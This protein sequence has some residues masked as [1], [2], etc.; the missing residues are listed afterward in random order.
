M[1]TLKPEE[2]QV[3]QKPAAPNVEKPPETAEEKAARKQGPKF[4]F[5]TIQPWQVKKLVSVWGA[6]LLVAVIFLS[7]AC[8]FLYTDKIQ[9]DDYWTEH[10]TQPEETL[11]R[12]AQKSA[13]ATVVTVGSYVESMKEMSLKTSSFRAVV[14]LWFRW[15]GH[16]DLD[17]SQNFHVYNG[18]INKLEVL[19][20]YHENGEHYQLFRCDVTVGKNYWTVRFPLE[21]HQL[22][23]YVESEFPVEEV[24]FA[25]DTENSGLNPNL[26]VSGFSVERSEV[27]VFFEEYEST[28]GDPALSEPITTAEFM[29]AIEVNRASAGLY[30][31]CF[32]ALVGTLTWVMIALF[33]CTYHRVDPLNLIPA[34]LFGTVTNI[35]VG[36]NIL[37]DSLQ[38][39]LLEFVNAWGILIILGVTLSIININRIRNKY[40]D[41]SFAAF[42]GRIMF[43]TLLA[44]CIG[45]NLL[46][47]LCAFRF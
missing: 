29:T 45:G 15:S 46:M 32:I 8:A 37:P 20:D 2:E 33:L 26:A 18:T 34:A 30:V 17:M 10:L 42:F 28:H 27:G 44:L 3:T 22:R 12:V 6:V 23:F 31:K 47:P 4:D 35:M 7:Y 41:R 16:D 13:D 40:E 21:S 11:A 5:R 1:Q 43:Y 38:M 39:G 19:R 24:T 9:E 25:P 36:A 14:Q